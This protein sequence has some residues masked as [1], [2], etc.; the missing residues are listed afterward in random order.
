M[1]NG[2]KSGKYEEFLNAFT[3]AH[4]RERGFAKYITKGKENCKQRL[5]RK[6]MA[7]AERAIPGD[8]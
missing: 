7:V 2:P 5:R 3:R 8:F 1:S 4:T 6:Q